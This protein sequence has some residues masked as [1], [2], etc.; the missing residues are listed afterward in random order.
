MNKKT[1][2]IVAIALTINW[3]IAAI[4]MLFCPT[5]DLALYYWLGSCLPFGILI[6]TLGGKLLFS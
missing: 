5:S 2:L 1:M 6:G 3:G 4:T